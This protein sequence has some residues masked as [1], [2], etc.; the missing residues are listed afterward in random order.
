MKY[1]TF[2]LIVGCLLIVS[3]TVAQQTTFDSKLP[4]DD[5]PMLCGCTEYQK[6]HCQ[7]V[8]TKT[9]KTYECI[10]W[11]STVNGS[12]QKCVQWRTHA[13]KTF[14]LAC[15]GKIPSCCKRVPDYDVWCGEHVKTRTTVEGG[16]IS[17][18]PINS[19]DSDTFMVEDTCEKLQWENN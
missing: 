19:P 3:Q 8:L 1:L 7:L 10:D 12:I 14:K 16:A 9:Q 17:V 13:H 2:P 4:M 6:Q 15:S 11:W 18:T 5:D